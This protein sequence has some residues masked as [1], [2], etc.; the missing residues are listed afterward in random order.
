MKIT[1][2]WD[3]QRDAVEFAMHNFCPSFGRP[4]G[5]VFAHEMGLGKTL[6]AVA[7]IAELAKRGKNV[8]PC[9]LACPLSMMTHWQKTFNEYEG[10]EGYAEIMH[11]DNKTKVPFYK[12]DVWIMTFTGLETK[13]QELV[14]KHCKSFI[15]D[16]AS[17]LKNPKAHFTR[18]M[19]KLAKSCAYR[20]LLT[21]TPLENSPMELFE[22]MNVAHPGWG[23]TRKQFQYCYSRQL[24]AGVKD[25]A[26][27]EQRLFARKAAA[28]VF[29]MLAPY[30]IRK[31]NQ[32]STQTDVLIETPMTT[33]QELVYN[34]V[35]ASHKDIY[36]KKRTVFHNGYKIRESYLD[37]IARALQ[38]KQMAELWSI[39]V[40]TH[41][42]MENVVTGKMDWLRDQLPALLRD[43]S[44]IAVFF[45][46]RAT[47]AQTLEIL[48]DFGIKT[49]VIH[50]GVCAADRELAIA[51]MNT[52]SAQVLLGT[53]R[54]CGYGINL[55]SIDKIVLAETD[56]N[57]A[58]DLQT[59]ARGSRPGNPNPVTVYRLVTPGTIEAHADATAS[60]K[61]TLSRLV[62]DDKIALRTKQHK[63]AAKAAES[64]GSKVVSFD[65]RQLERGMIFQH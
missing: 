6:T 28:Q 12:A 55:L 65:L 13:Y 27:A 14:L 42:R 64:L 5:V 63:A 61:L 1:A 18:A 19:K 21:A 40:G 52:G 11:Q 45:K 50:G 16:E 48:K 32:S 9:V 43:G 25:G 23:G 38:Q 47:L 37:P 60:A 22:L 10:F 49:V 54:S 34:E 4:S 20:L 41:A 17:R 46:Y 57:A 33:E 8:F 7:T 24:R 31:L 15:V 58:I 26:N 29:R 39:L 51:S 53:S 30:L 44:K 3:H 62:L 2:L 35:K 59:A 36:K 56:W